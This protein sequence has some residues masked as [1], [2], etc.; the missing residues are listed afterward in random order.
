M[1]RGDMLD[2]IVWFGAYNFGRHK[3]GAHT[4]ELGSSDA[5]AFIVRGRRSKTIIAFVCCLGKYRV[6]I[7]INLGD[8][9]VLLLDAVGV[10]WNCAVDI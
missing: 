5:T 9:A 10:A 6:S 4:C 1:V 7:V 3:F 8:V 2:F